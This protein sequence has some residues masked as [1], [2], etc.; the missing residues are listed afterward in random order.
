MSLIGWS[1]IYLKMR[2]FVSIAIS[3]KPILNKWVVKLSLEMDLRIGRKGEKDLRCMLDRLGVFIIRLE[4]L[5]Q[6]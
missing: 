5:L 6:I 1:I 2:H 3:L 4:K